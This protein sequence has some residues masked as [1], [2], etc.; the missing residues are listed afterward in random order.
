MPLGNFIGAVYLKWGVGHLLVNDFF[1][2]AI[3]NWASFR[4]ILGDFIYSRRRFASPTTVRDS[5]GQLT[6]F[7]QNAKSKRRRQ[8]QFLILS[9]KGRSEFFSSGLSW[10]HPTFARQ[11][12]SQRW[13]KPT[14][15]SLSKAQVPGLKPWP[16]IVARAYFK[17]PLSST[18]S[19]GLNA[20]SLRH[21]WAYF[22]P[23]WRKPDSKAP[24]WLPF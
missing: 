8:K 24:A 12:D 11:L 7:F 5:R 18:L 14:F 9:S 22:E 20:P 13:N 21:N 23:I 2:W 1:S 6:S 19:L 17:S 15:L 16:K 10:S 4:N 3:C